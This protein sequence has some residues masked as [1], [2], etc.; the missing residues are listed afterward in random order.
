M[1]QHSDLLGC[2]FT[3]VCFLS[4]SIAAPANWS[5]SISGC[6][7]M[8]ARWPWGHTKG[9]SWRC[10]GSHEEEGAACNCCLS[11]KPFASFAG[12][13]AGAAE[14]LGTTGEDRRVLCTPLSSCETERS[15]IRGHRRGLS[16]ARPAHGPASFPSPWQVHTLGRT[17]ETHRLPV[18]CGTRKCSQAT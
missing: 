11:R 14:R 7:R 1:C 2:S 13:K 4:P 16:L 6:C 8:T 17:T 5:L 15:I 3:W 18:L 10:D 12:G 9:F